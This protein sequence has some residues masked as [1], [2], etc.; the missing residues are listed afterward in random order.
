[1]KYN[2]IIHKEP[3]YFL[4]ER[5][6]IFSKSDEIWI[7]VK[8]LKIDDRQYYGFK[9]TCQDILI[10]IYDNGESFKY[11]YRINWAGSSS[12]N[13]NNGKKIFKALR[14]D[15]HLKVLEKEAQER[16]NTFWANV[17]K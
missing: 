12:V 4:I 13:I 9:S 6:H 8:S 3:N 10:G 15:Y 17:D 11:A 2:V 16:S 7:K 14:N 5:N 1:M